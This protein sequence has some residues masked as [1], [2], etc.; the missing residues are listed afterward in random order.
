MFHVV[1]LDAAETPMQKT[2][3]RRDTLLQFFDRVEPTLVAME[4]CPGS[5]WLARRIRELGHD[6]RIIPVSS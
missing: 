5:Q 4:A 6:V 3:F 2:K 1:G